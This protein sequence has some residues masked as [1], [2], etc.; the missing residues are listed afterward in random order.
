MDVNIY[1]SNQ[2]LQ[3][4]SLLSF[5]LLA[6]QPVNVLFSTRKPQDIRTNAIH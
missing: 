3:G 1:I 4:L 2:T 6:N 5:W